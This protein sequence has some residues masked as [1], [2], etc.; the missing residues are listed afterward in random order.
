MKFPLIVKHKDIVLKLYN[1]MDYPRGKAARNV[2]AFDLDGT[3]I[4]TIES[5]GGDAP[6]DYYTN[7]S[8]KNGEIHAFNF[9][10]FDCIIDERNGKIISK[11]FTK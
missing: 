4:W 9:Q 5:L 3:L 2:E 8:L 11:T 7:V 10:C 1:W 6:T